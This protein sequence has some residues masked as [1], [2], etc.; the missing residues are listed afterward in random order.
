MLVAGFIVGVPLLV[1]IVFLVSLRRIG[2]AGVRQYQSGGENSVNIQ[3]GGN[4]CH[5]RCAC[6]MTSALGIST[7]RLVRGRLCEMH[8]LNTGR[9][10]EWCR[11]PQV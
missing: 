10:P 3:S 11:G 8:F 7:P 1:F 9:W 4:L 6:Y 5:P 2:R